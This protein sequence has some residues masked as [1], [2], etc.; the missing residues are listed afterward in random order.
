MLNRKER[1]QTPRAAISF[2]LRFRLLPVGGAGYYDARVQD[3]SPAGVRFRAPD[4]V[5]VRSGL[6]FELIIPGAAPVRSFGRAA[7][8]RELAD[9][10]GFEVGSSFVDLSTSS[11][12]AI[13]RHL[14][15]QPVLAGA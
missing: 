11:R 7:W 9:D 4:E 13:E 3:L 15:R 14:Q 6:L 2:P 10:G 5:R 8:V 1:R 12:K